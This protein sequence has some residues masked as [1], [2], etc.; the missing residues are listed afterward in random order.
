MLLATFMP[1]HVSAVFHETAPGF[2]SSVLGLRSRNFLG[3][4][5]IR[6]ELIGRFFPPPRCPEARDSL[7]SCAKEFLAR[8][9]EREAS[10]PLLPSAFLPPAQKPRAHSAGA[11]K[12]CQSHQ[13]SLANHRSSFLS[14]CLLKSC[15]L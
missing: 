12:S 9:P 13:F 5:S 10:S 6:S 3:R 4:E 15:C 14:S 2:L 7:S 1:R 11:A 8:V